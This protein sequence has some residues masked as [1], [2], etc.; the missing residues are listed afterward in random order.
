MNYT[1]VLTNNLSTLIELSQNVSERDC[2]LASKTATYIYTSLLF[3][4]AIIATM[5]NLLVIIIICKQE[6]LHRPSVLLLG[7][8]ATIDLLTGCIITPIKTSITLAHTDTWFH[9]FWC[10]FTAVVFLE[11]SVVT[12]ITFDR[13]CHVYYLEK[14]SFTKERFIA[15]LIFNWFAP[16]VIIIFI[17]F[18]VP[19]GIGGA[20]FTLVYF[21]FSIIAMVLAY[22]AM[23]IILRKHTSNVNNA[24]RHDYMEKQWRAVNTTLILIITLTTMNILPIMSIT[25]GFMGIFSRTICAV[26]FSSLLANSAVN[27]LIYCLRIP[28]MKKHIFRLL[29]IEKIKRR[30]NATGSPVESRIINEKFSDILNIRNT[31]IDIMDTRHR[32]LATI[33]SNI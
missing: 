27:P 9:T 2:W 11:L 10:M 29:R 26:T 3:V 6:T 33:N 15:I 23:I 30:D 19:V 13:L 18:R 31:D 17:V 7:I 14:Y 16:S 22:V 1:K 12:L 25:L 21:F 32:S 20:V 4:F 8:L 28:S 24:M 5:E